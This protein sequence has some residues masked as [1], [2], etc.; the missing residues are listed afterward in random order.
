VTEKG[1]RIE[2]AWCYCSKHNRHYIC[3]EGCPECS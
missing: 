2:E 1:G 3:S